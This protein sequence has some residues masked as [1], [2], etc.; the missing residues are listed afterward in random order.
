MVVDDVAVTDA[1]N[2]AAMGDGRAGGTSLQHA[3]RIDRVARDRVFVAAKAVQ[4]G[5]GHDGVTDPIKG[6]WCQVRSGVQ[7]GPVAM[8]VPGT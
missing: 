2:P 3:A 4:G 1:G 6:R 8:T 5:A 7:P